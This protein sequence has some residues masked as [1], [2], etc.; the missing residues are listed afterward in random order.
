[1]VPEVCSPPFSLVIS[2]RLLWPGVLYRRALEERHRY[3]VIKVEL[4]EVDEETIM[5]TYTI[6]KTSFSLKS[7]VCQI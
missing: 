7:G 2:R 1:M 4:D 5:V 3:D 6:T